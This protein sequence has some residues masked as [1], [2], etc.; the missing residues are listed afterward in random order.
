[1][2]SLFLPEAAGESLEGPMGE[3]CV[4]SAM[5]SFVATQTTVALRREFLLI[6]KCHFLFTHSSIQ[7]PTHP[8]FLLSI[9]LFKKFFSMPSWSVLHEFRNRQ[10]YIRL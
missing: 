9:K 4:R 7:P 6:L 1:M 3:L 5:I 2:S 10:A 8:S